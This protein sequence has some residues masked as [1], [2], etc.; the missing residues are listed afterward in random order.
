MAENRFWRFEAI[1]K[2][3]VCGYDSRKDHISIYLSSV[4]IIYHNPIL[5][6]VLEYW[7]PGV[8]FSLIPLPESSGKDTKHTVSCIL[9]SIEHCSGIFFL[10]K[11]KVANAVPMSCEVICVSPAGTRDELLGRRQP[12]CKF[13]YEEFPTATG[14]MYY[15]SSN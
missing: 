14:G 13:L 8:I 9:S 2:R 11:P 4:I 10:L 3:A 12:Q 1:H 15:C 6:K 5:A 7:M